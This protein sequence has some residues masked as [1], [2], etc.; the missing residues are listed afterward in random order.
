MLA[1]AANGARLDSFCA[2]RGYGP[3][4]A[5]D[6]CQPEGSEVARRPKPG[7]AERGGKS[8]ARATKGLGGADPSGPGFGGPSAVLTCPDGSRPPPVFELRSLPSSLPPVVPRAARPSRQRS[9]D[10]LRPRL[11]CGAA[12]G[13]VEVF[14]ELG[15]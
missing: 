10:V 2:E 5:W 7:G 6:D 14:I 11:G 12:S 9:G 15:S 8:G 13:A 3:H 4:S 1:L